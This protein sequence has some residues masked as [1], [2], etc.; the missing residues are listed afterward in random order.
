MELES[1]TL[2]DLTEGQILTRL[3]QGLQWCCERTVDGSTVDDLHVAMVVV[4]ETADVPALRRQFPNSLIVSSLH[5]QKDAQMEAVDLHLPLGAPDEV[6]S[7]LLVHARNYWRKNRKVFELVTDVAMRR[8]RMHQLN[9]IS[10]ALTAEMPQQELLQTILSEARRI[11]GC[12]GGSLYL[13]EQR[14]DDPDGLVFKLAQNDVVDFPSVESRLP[15][16]SE[17]IAGYVAVTGY[18]LNIEDV[19]RLQDDMPYRFNCSFDEKFG[20]RTQSMLTLPMRDHRER[21]VGVLQFI[22]KFDDVAGVVRH[23]GEE[24][25]EVLRAIASQAAV[26]LQKNSLVEDINQLFESFVQASVKTI[27]QRDPSTSGHSFRVAETTVSLLKA[28][29]LSGVNQYANLDLTSEHL[30]EVRYAALLHDFGKIGVPEA[31]LVKA[32]K[33]SDERLEVIGYRVELQKE[34]LRRRAVEQEIDLLHH[35]PVDQEVARRRVYRQ[36]EKQLSVLDQYIDWVVQANSPNVLDQ[37]DYQHLDEI[38]DYSFR[39]LDGTL[40]GVITDQDVLALSIRR[41]S[42]TP[43]ERR[44]IQSHVVY[45]TEFL[46]VLPWPPELAGIPEIAGSHHERIDGSGYP[47]GLVGEQIPLASQ[48]MAVCDIYDALT[49]MDRPYKASMSNDQAFD[50]LHDEARRGLLDTVLVDIF[51]ESGSHRLSAPIT[52]TA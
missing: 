12:E 29:P 31:I 30:R 8:Q 14:E 34:R 16:T 15:L 38:R 45:T 24:T 19:Y 4:N 50:I 6:L 1:P 49:A 41:G 25:V 32:N 22:N 33:L 35:Q 37:G 2:I 27:E 52:Q 10:M 28:L 39:E 9:E 7:Q 20:Y 23:F 40:G 13:I 5:S 42:L 18:E 47:Q 21:V 51:I 36:L 46:S 11:A 3:A 43:E 26:S 17:S 48:V 44:E